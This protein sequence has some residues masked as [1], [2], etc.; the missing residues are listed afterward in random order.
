MTKEIR[1]AAALL[2]AS[3][4][5]VSSTGTAFGAHRCPHHDGAVAPTAA[6]VAD[7]AGE[8]GH[9]AEHAGSSHGQEGSPGSAAHGACTCLGECQAGAAPTMPS[10]AVGPDLPPPPAAPQAVRHAPPVPRASLVPFSLPWGNAPPT[11]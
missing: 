9:A 3:L 1:R 6:G 11:L 7:G 2:V 5:A 4:L 8:A 10:P